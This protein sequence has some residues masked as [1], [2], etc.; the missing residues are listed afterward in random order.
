MR[1]LGI[2][3]NKDYLLL[4]LTKK[5]EFLSKMRVILLDRLIKHYFLL[6]LTLNLT[7]DQYLRDKIK[8]Q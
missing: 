3:C 5:K 2:R 4:N 6:K 8:R 1:V 7:L